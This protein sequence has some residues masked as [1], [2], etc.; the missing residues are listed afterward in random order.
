MLRKGNLCILVVLAI[1]FALVFGACGETGGDDTTYE[2]GQ[3]GPG[4]GIIFYRNL[5]GFTVHMLNPSDNYTAYYLEAAP[6]DL[7]GVGDTP[8]SS[9]RYLWTI[10]DFY[11]LVPGLSETDVDETDWAIG[12]GRKNTALILDSIDNPATNAPAAYYCYNYDISNDWF[13]PSL[14]ELKMLYQNK[15]AA[16]ITVL[17]S[18][19]NH[20]SSSQSALYTAWCLTFSDGSDISAHAKDNSFLVRPIRAF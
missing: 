17:D 8:I 12:R 5:S 9:G 4:G 15:D 18:S 14:N 16:G 13:L 7:S 11:D 10:N 6:E 3:T 19:M 2:L 20:W 1:I